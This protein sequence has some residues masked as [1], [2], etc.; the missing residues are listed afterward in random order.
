MKNIFK[1]DENK[2]FHNLKYIEKVA[3]VGGRTFENTR[4]GGSTN[5]ISA[6]ECSVAD[7]FELVKQ[8]DPEF[9]P[10]SSS[11]VVNADG[12]PKVVY[13][14]T[15]KIFDTFDDGLIGNNTHNQG[16][17]GT[18]F[19]FTDNQ[20]TAKEYSAFGNGNNQT[21]MPVYIDIKKPF[22]WNDIRTKEDLN[23][24]K[25]ELGLEKGTLKWTEGSK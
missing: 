23:R 9:N 19:Y 13:H 6:T 5:D 21:V 16:F 17:F 11:V 1:A 4:S 2:R 25:E 18:G 15:N 12:T 14:G 8:L 20:S 24:I 10:R 22:K 3:D 7:L